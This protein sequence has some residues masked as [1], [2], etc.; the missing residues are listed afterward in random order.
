MEEETQERDDVFREL[1]LGHRGWEKG[2]RGGWESR[3]ATDCEE[4]G[5]CWAKLCSFWKLAE[6]AG[7]LNQRQDMLRASSGVTHLAEVRTGVGKTLGG[8]D[9]VGPVAGSASGGERRPTL[10]RRNISWILFIIADTRE[11]KT[12]T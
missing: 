8:G 11:S 12:Q 1:I 2:C 6:Q 5:S 7:M 4:P 10:V 3:L 9:L